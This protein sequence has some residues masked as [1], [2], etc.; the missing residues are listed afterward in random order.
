MGEIADQIVNGEICR[1]CCCPDGEERGYPF[2][3]SECGGGKEESDGPITKYKQKPKKSNCPICNKLA[4]RVG[5]LDHIKDCHPELL[6]K[7][8]KALYKVLENEK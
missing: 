3:C 4:K 1:E 6:E 2:T 7:A 8:C 5:F